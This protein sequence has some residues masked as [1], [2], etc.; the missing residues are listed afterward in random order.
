[1]QKAYVHPRK[2]EDC[3]NCFE[4]YRVPFKDKDLLVLMRT[5]PQMVVVP[6]YVVGNP[7]KN[8]D[9]TTLY[10]IETISED[11]RK[12]IHKLIEDELFHINQNFNSDS[13]RIG[14]W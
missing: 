1:M 5:N 3:C 13:L 2:A 9:G 8:Q 10:T 14:F 6:G 12:E 7:I 4:K 11:E